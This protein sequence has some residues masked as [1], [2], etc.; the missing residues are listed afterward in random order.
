MHGNGTTTLYT[1]QTNDLVIPISLSQLNQA[2]IVILNLTITC[3]DG[4]IGISVR[5]QNKNCK[6]N[7]DVMTL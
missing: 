6:L 2:L 3:N 7:I 5:K 1:G 4:N